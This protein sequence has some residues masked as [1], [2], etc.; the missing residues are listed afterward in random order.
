MNSFRFPLE[1]ALEW[2]RRQLEIEEGRFKQQ[3]AALAEL[4]RARAELESA[5][6][7]A[8]L[9]VRGWAPLLGRDLSALAGYR[10]DVKNKEEVLAARRVERQRQLE[11]QQR[12]MLEARRRCRLLEKLRARRWEEWRV[13]ADREIEQ[14][15]A[16][17]YLAGIVRNRG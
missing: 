10:V 3:A 12:V 13:A 14:F 1:R 5:A 6:I 7:R 8:E 15:A 16:E 4:D 17:N 11:A 2:R 9:Q